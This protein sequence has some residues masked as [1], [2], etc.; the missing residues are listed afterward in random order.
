VL[1]R[2]CF[3]GW[4]ERFHTACLTGFRT[5]QFDHRARIGRWRE[6]MVKAHHAMHF[7]AAEVERLGNR[8]HSLGIHTAKCVLHIM[9]DWQQ[10]AA[11]G[12]MARDNVCKSVWLAHGALM[13][14]RLSMPQQ[15]APTLVRLMVAINA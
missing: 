6:I 14:E 15:G 12:A 8:R 11:P 5:A 2:L 3:G 9:E 13:A 7:R 1:A 4:H 10:G